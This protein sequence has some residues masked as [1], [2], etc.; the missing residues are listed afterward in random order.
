M[1]ISEIA[2]SLQE[3]ELQLVEV[4]EWSGKPHTVKVKGELSVFCTTAKALGCSVVF[5]AS[6]TLDSDDF[7]IS[8]ETSSYPSV[9]IDLDLIDHDPSLSR[10]KKYIG[11]IGAYS[12]Y[13]PFIQGYLSIDIEESWYLKFWEAASAAA[14]VG[15]EKEKRQQEE[16]EIKTQERRTALL[17]KLNALVCDKEFMSMSTQKQMLAYAIENIPELAEVPNPDLKR[18]VQEIDAKAKAKGLR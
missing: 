14:S 16:R 5:A 3:F 1:D 11:Q 15:I 13:A 17:K 2:T 10:Y 12:L 6:Q 18:A 7:E 9:S 8:L 4:E